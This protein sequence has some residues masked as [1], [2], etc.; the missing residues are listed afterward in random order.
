[1]KY[2]NCPHPTTGNSLAVMLM[3][4]PL[5][6]RLDLLKPDITRTVEKSFVTAPSSQ[7]MRH[8]NIG[9]LVL[10]RNS[11]RGDLWSEGIV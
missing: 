6:S 11:E 9:T 1:M 4:H 8:F 7:Q 2:H 10:V 5:R 3:G